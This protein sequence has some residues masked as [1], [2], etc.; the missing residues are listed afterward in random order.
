M[1]REYCRTVE[2]VDEVKELVQ[3]KLSEIVRWL[4]EKVLDVLLQSKETKEMRLHNTGAERILF[5]LQTLHDGDG[6]RRWMYDGKQRNRR[7]EVANHMSSST[8]T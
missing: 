8:D 6:E 5:Q 1:K 4:R 2:S 3:Q 7:N